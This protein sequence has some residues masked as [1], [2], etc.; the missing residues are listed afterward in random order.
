MD[1]LHFVVSMLEHI[2]VQR[3]RFAHPRVQLGVVPVRV[4]C[5]GV[6]QYAAILVDPDI[7]ALEVEFE[8]TRAGHA[9]LSE[10]RR[11]RRSDGA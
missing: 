8:L 3:P 1:F 6:D 4:V 5:V 10:R 2:G 7:S 11:A 9:K